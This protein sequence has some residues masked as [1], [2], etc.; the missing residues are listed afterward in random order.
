MSF[1]EW[2]EWLLVACGV[3]ILVGLLLT[4][5]KRASRP[6]PVLSLSPSAPMGQPDSL[7]TERTEERRRTP[8]R[9]ANPTLVLIS[10]ATG[11]DVPTMGLVVDRSAG[12]F[13]LDV[14]DGVPVGTILK[15]R[16]AE[17]PDHVPWVQ[18]EVRNCRPADNGWRVGCQFERPPPPVVLALLG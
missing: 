11:L 10:E 18:G 14:E 4:L 12:G 1:S 15:I 2:M 7:G 5:R 16:A 17:A 13:C 6:N 9:Q 3:A 8:R